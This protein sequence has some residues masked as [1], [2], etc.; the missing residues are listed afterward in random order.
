MTDNYIKLCQILSQGEP[1]A[2]GHPT[3]V[4]YQEDCNG[5]ILVANQVYPLVLACEVID[6]VSEA[7]F[8]AHGKIVS[9]ASVNV[10]LNESPALISIRQAVYEQL[11]GYYPTLVK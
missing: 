8:H 9:F 6:W 7:D 3:K 2:S 10:T 1:D 5:N 11:L 4:F